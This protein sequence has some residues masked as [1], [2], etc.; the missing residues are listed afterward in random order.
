MTELYLL[1]PI[2]TGVIQR[3]HG[4]KVCP[5]ISTSETGAQGHPLEVSSGIIVTDILLM[6][7][8]VH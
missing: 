7:L 2:M 8:Q 3:G 6:L 4:E 1:R 5:M